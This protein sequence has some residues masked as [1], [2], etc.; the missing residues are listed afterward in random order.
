MDK[1]RRR[2]PEA[3]T[4]D[5]FPIVRRP[6]SQPISLIPQNHSSDKCS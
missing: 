1:K 2:H 6:E 5:T 3:C 4:P